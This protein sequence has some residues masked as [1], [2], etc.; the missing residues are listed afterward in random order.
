MPLQPYTTRLRN[1]DQI[2]RSPLP[3]ATLA[4]RRALTMTADEPAEKS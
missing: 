1:N 3:L 4:T 2:A